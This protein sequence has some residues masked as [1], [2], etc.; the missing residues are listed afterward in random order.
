MVQQL[1]YG[2][3]VPM[4]EFWWEQENC[5]LLKTSRPTVGST[6]LLFNGKRGCLQG[7]NRAEREVNHSPSS[8]AEIKNEWS[9]TSTAPICFHDVDRGNF[10]PT[11]TFRQLEGTRPIISS[12]E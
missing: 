4:L 8:I 5:L 3:D 12:V 1:G 6:G 9:Y 10:A 2:M 11:F 7:V